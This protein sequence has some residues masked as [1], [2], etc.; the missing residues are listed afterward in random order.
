MIGAVLAKRGATTAYDILGRQDLEAI[1]DALHEDAVWEYPGDTVLAGRIEGKPAI[2]EWFRMWFE[3]M[4]ETR[5]TVRHATVENIFALGLTNT[6]LVEWEL[7]QVDRDGKR[8]HVTGVTAF[9]VE[10]GKIR[11]G[12]DYIFDQDVESTAYPPRATAEAGPQA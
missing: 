3:L 10:R 8:Y 7:D 1:A 5:F 6:S 9:H 12:K 11:H 2:V 4:P